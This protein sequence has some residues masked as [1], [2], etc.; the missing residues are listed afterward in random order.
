MRCVLIQAEEMVSDLARGKGATEC[1]S[2]APEF[3]LKRLFL[4]F[5]RRKAWGHSFKIRSTHFT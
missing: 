4:L 2:V 3:M 1:Y 5:R